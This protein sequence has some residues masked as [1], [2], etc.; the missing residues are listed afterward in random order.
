MVEIFKEPG[1]VFAISAFITIIFI[2][3]ESRMTKMK[4][5]WRYYIKYALFVGGL[6]SFFVYTNN[7]GI[8][9]GKYLSTG[10]GRGTVSRSIFLE[11]F[12]SD[13]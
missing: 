4:K 11:N 8:K 3:I 9:F 13:Y 1:A 10:G 6:S 12:P 5:P 7:K 2:F